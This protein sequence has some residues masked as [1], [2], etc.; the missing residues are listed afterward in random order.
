M[1]IP[2]EARKLAKELFHLAMKTGKLDPKAVDGIAL[3]IEQKKPRHFFQVLKE[4]TRLVRL[5]LLKHHAVVDSATPLA[6]EMQQSIRAELSSRFGQDT[7][8]EF[9]TK[10]DLI[11]GMRV[12]LGSDVW[13][14][15]VQSRLESLRQSI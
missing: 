8:F 14:G 1:K 7:T 12:R 13:D 10:P 11:G 15:S 9:R 3:T 6:P 4:F 2:R 5:E